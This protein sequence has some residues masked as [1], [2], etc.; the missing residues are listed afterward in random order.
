MGRAILKQCFVASQE[1]YAF[2]EQF[3]LSK[4]TWTGNLLT[5]LLSP[6]ALCVWLIRHLAQRLYFSFEG[7]IYVEVRCT[8]GAAK[9]LNT[10]NRKL[11]ANHFK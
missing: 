3:I 2:K 5:P 8:Y 4:S 11:Y 10:S 9:L 6:S 1:S 7:K